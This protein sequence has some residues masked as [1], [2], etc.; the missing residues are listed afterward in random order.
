MFDQLLKTSCKD[1]LTNIKKARINWIK[2]PKKFDQATA[3][4]KFTNLYTNFSSTGDWDK[5]DKEQAKIIS[6]TTDIK[7]T[8]S[9][10][11]KLPKPPQDPSCNRHLPE[12]TR[13]LEV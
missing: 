7:D 6:L 11:A 2:K 10:V 4:S 3:M 5:A 8:K 1:F 13:S 12:R 9:Q